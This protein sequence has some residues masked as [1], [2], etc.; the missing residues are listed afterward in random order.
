MGSIPML[1]DLLNSKNGKE[2]KEVGGAWVTVSSAGEELKQD[3]LHLMMPF[4][5]NLLFDFY[6]NLCYNIYIR[7]EHWKFNT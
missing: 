7:Y 3:R 6:K 4:S 1:H 5:C 2:S